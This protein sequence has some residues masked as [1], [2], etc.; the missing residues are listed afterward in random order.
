M[1]RDDLLFGTVDAD[2]LAVKMQRIFQDEEYTISIKQWAV[3]Q[4]AKFSWSVTGPSAV[5][6]LES[7]Y[8]QKRTPRHVPKEF[9]RKPRLAFFS[10]LPPV[11]SGVADYSAELLRELGRFYDVECIVEQSEIADPWVQANFTIR[12]VSFFERHASSYDRLVY[13][14]GNSEFHTH[15]LRLLPKFPGVV[16]LHDFFISGVLNWLGN[17]G[18]RPPEDFLRHLYST[19]GLPALVFVQKEGREAAAARY[20]ANQVVFA[21]AF[22][23]IVHSEFSLLRAGEIYGLTG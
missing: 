19:H 13:S 12:D 14:V 18:Q 8:E 9:R 1:G 22:G 6:A 23:I 16:I 17:T 10:P 7:L 11:R 4:A 3:E 2:E 5:E 20:A 21:N 15:M